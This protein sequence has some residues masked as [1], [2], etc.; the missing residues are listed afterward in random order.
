MMP[1]EVLDDTEIQIG[2]VV[3]EEHPSG[4]AIPTSIDSKTY[5]T[6]YS[7][8]CLVKKLDFITLATLLRCRGHMNRRV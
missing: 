8:L 1:I 5:A 4:Q 2:S 7:F 6:V 3:R